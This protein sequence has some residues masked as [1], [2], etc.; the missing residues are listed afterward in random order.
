MSGR[1]RGR[2]VLWQICACS[3]AHGLSCSKH[4]N[5]R[6]DSDMTSRLRAYAVVVLALKAM[7]QRRIARKC[8][9]DSASQRET[10]SRLPANRIRD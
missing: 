2:I 10:R 9:A 7:L 4:R 1:R 8:G 6:R 3:S 5:A